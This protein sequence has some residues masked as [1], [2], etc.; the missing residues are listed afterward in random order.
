MKHNKL[1]SVIAL[2]ISLE[3][4]LSP[5][6]ALA[7]NGQGAI[8]GA[9]ILNTLQFATGLY[10]T[11]RGGGSQMPPHV[12]T[13]MAALQQQQTPAPDKHFTLANMQKIPGLMEYIAVQNQKQAASGGKPINPASLNCNTLPTTLYEA[14]NEVCRNKE[15]SPLNGNPQLQ[16][17]EAFAYYNQYMQIDKLYSNYSVD[18]NVGGQA[19]GV[20][21]MNDAKKVLE[22]FFAYRLEQLDVVVAN[23]EAATAKF[24]EQSEMDL[25]SIRESSAILNGESSRFAAEFKDKDIFDYAKRF[26]NPACNSILS[27]DKF[28][29][30]GKQGGG[31]LAIEKKLKADF[32]S[33]PAGSKYSVEQYIGKHASVEEDI[34]KMADKVATQSNLNF[35]QI[36]SGGYSNF[37]GGLSSDISSETGVNR[38]L[39]KDFF[40][41]LQQKFT[42]SNNKLKDEVR[43]V[44][45]ELGSRGGEALNQLGNIDNDSS[46]DAELGSL[47]N[48][49]KG[50][51]VNKSGIDEAL[52]RIYDPNL[53]KEANKHSAN[54]IKK[55]IK[56]IISDINRSPEEKLKELSAIDGVNNGRFQLKMDDGYEVSEVGAD[57]KVSKQKRSADGNTPYAYLKDVMTTCES[58]FQ[59]N[60]LGN[61]LSAKEAIKRL[62]SLKQDYKKA[63]RQHAK[64]IKEEIIKKMINCGGDNSVANSSTVGSCG[65]EKLNMN[66]P[67][68]CAK[69]A[70]SCAKN[71]Q[72][73]TEK[74]QKFVKEI[75]A[76]RTKRVANYNDQVEKNRKQLVGMFDTALMKYLSEGESFR[77]HFGVG[78]SS[79][80]ADRIITNGSDIS[81]DIVGDP[82]D[83][84]QVKDPKVYLAMV[85]NNIKTLQKSIKDQQDQIIGPSGTLAAHIKQT[86]DNYKSQVLTKAKKLASDCLAAYNSYGAMMKAQREQEDK[87]RSELGEKNGALCSTYSRVM[88]N[89]PNGGCKTF[90]EVG[91]DALMASGKAGGNSGEISYMIQEMEHRCNNVP[92]ES[93]NAIVICS[94]EL[95]PS[96]TEKYFTMSKGKKLEDACAAISTP[97]TE[98]PFCP[99]TETKTIRYK[100]VEAKSEEDA[101][102]QRPTDP[103]TH[104]PSGYAAGEVCGTYSDTPEVSETGEGKYKFSTECSKKADKPDCKETEDL[105]VDLYKGAYDRGDLFTSSAAAPIPA[106][107]AG[108]YNGFPYNNKG[109][110][111]QQGSDP[112]LGGSKG[113]SK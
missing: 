80:H 34:R 7:D 37:L 20:G 17:D 111:G 10:D 105:I 26:E 73:C 12:A 72:S 21:C 8:T 67:S 103:K 32:G 75:K 99:I 98:S 102:G 95:H 78:F 11:V 2:S 1:P 70:F 22:G 50:E 48:R 27:K 3:L 97:T 16:A 52:G 9:N 18:S 79:P 6:P 92:K 59:V 58:Q 49:I 83:S 104:P 86:Q 100:I 55:R 46:F 91:K 41:D 47:E 90:E 23:M 43:L 14:N 60:K 19:Y 106:T 77:A 82:G 30:L 84:F 42:A 53:S 36:T 93:D 87:M 5:L 13:D 85:K 28:G 45:A 112:L 51:C 89:N 56:A 63:A 57:G 96:M 4:V 107:C 24:E 109:G 65:P 54:Q 68:F 81:K 40:S 66:S 61:K 76:E 110:P 101:R 113:L 88:S 29:D 108:L 25:K 35:S 44:S 39:T 62:R 15:V 33:T 71:M 31:L 74:A 94:G 38:A 64:D 69:G